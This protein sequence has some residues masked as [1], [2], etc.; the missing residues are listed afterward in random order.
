M[1]AKDKKEKTEQPAAKQSQPKEKLTFK[2][3]LARNQFLKNYK[4]MWPFVKP[5]WGRALLGVLLTIPVGSLDAAIAMF[6]KPFMDNVMVEK[7]PRFSMAIPFLI[8][9]FTVLQGALNYAAN[10]MNTWVGNKITIGL[11]RRLFDKLLSMDTAYFDR[12]SSGV[13]VYR[14]SNDA[15]KASNSLVNNLKQFLSKFFSSIA[16]VCVLFYQ[17]WQLAF[18]AIF[19]LGVAFFPLQ[20]VRKK[21][22]EITSKAV[23]SGAR[24]VTIYNETFSG[25][26]TIHSF[27]LEDKQRERFREVTDYT[28]A[29]SMKMVK[30]TNW[31]SPVMHIVMSIGVALVIGFGSFLIVSGRI[32][33]GNFVAFIAALMLLY[34]PMKSVGNNFVQIQQSF[35]AID[36]IFNILAIEP[37]IVDKPQAKEL[38]EIK[39]D[40]HFEDVHFSYVPDKEVLK[41]IN[42]DIKVGETVAL[43]G[44]S[45]GG[46]TTISSL[47]PR[48]YDIQGGHI[49]ID[50][51]DVKDLTLK[52]L[53]KNIAMVFQDNFLFSGS[54]REN[55]LLGNP[56]VN[57]EQI[58]DALKNACLDDFVRG[59]PEQ[60]NTEI[61]ERGI[62]LSGGQKQRVAI[63]RAFVKNAPVVILDEATSAL[64]NKSEKVVQEAIDNL[65]K[66]RT[67]IVI[68]HRL[69]T[70][71]NADKIVV[72]NDGEIA[73]MGTHE[74]LLDKKGAY[75][76][77][78]S[79]QF[80]RA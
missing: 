79:S 63:A 49:R 31:L 36:R 19:I 22:K 46:K 3:W 47:I 30:G 78:Y 33:S 55:I 76:A 4:R 7:Q 2:Q 11:K 54:I 64:D 74:E 26:K 10:Y 44:N 6:L 60:L 15:E 70:V 38:H 62:L 39:K 23:V 56:T 41:G 58:W 52:S 80:K 48:L 12:N 27:T 71:Q 59:L 35:M 67:V 24:I 18:I 73:E 1:K 50:G 9:G 34:T 57:D 8:V 17:S 75:F 77:L 21:M 40:I 29:L 16:L 5:F 68:A 28:F 14:Y 25:N 45:G 72:I 51:T 43:V 69:S 53:R 13:I 32:T 65:M 61:G 66:N 20:F 37:T 42:L